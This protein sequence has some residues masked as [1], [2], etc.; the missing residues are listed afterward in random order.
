MFQQLFKVSD[1]GK[2]SKLLSVVDC[3]GPLQNGR[4]KPHGGQV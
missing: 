1:A 2:H 4:L 3:L